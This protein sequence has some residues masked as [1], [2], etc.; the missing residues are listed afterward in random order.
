MPLYDVNVIHYHTVSVHALDAEEAADLAIDMET[1]GECWEME[2]GAVCLVE[3]CCEESYTPYY[4]D[5]A[6]SSTEPT[7]SGYTPYMPV[8]L[9]S[10]RTTLPNGYTT[11]C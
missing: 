7:L 8:A 2:V 4:S 10:T 5:S 3:D 6:D 9:T 11:Y 1:H